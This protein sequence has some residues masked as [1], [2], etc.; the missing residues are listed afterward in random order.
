[1]LAPYFPLPDGI[2]AFILRAAMIGRADPCRSKSR[3]AVATCDATENVFIAAI[4]YIQTT[5]YK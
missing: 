3:D 4:K 1:V 5:D 2:D